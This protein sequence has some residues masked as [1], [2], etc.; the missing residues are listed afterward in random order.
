MILAAG[1]V[2]WYAQTSQKYKT[3]NLRELILPLALSTLF[4]WSLNRFFAPT[5]THESGAP[6]AGQSFKAAPNADAARPLFLTTGLHKP[7]VPSQKSFTIGDA[8]LLID[9]ETA[10]INSLQYQRARGKSSVLLPVIESENSTQSA[11]LVAFDGTAPCSFMLTEQEE[12]NGSLALTFL[13]GYEDAEISKT[14]Q[15][16]PEKGILELTLAVVPGSKP[17]TPRIIIP[18][19]HDAIRSPSRAVVLTET[20][21]ISLLAAKNVIDTFWLTPRIFG[22]ET[23]FA[24]SALIKDESNFARRGYYTTGSNGKLVTIIEGPEISTPQTWHMTFFCGPKEF[25]LLAAADPRLEE[26]LEYG[27]LGWLVKLLIRVL[28]FINSIVGNYGW[29]IVILTVGL[30]L[31]L[32]PGLMAS[33]GSDGTKRRA[34][35]DRKMRYLE[36]RYKDDPHTLAQEKV[37]LMKKMGPSSREILGCLPILIQIPVFFALNRLLSTSVDLYGAPFIGWIHDLSI[38]DPYYIFPIIITISSLWR[39][40]STVNDPRMGVIMFIV[41]V[42]L[43]AASTRFAAGLS[44]YFL[45]AAL[46]GALQMWIIARMRAHQ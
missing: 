41:A 25:E 38:P 17:L 3:M 26:T 16:L 21:T 39:G 10:A 20:G 34:E 31:I 15:L 19:P 27:W 46:T 12:H 24:L 44:L 30:Q 23:Y 42:G 32:T 6:R 43:G 36:Q 29:S 7:C 28:A 2:L 11:Y 1:A 4:V 9:V 40:T 33:M 18:A 5:D 45:C 8:T 35:Y 37:E 14:I 13:G 22:G